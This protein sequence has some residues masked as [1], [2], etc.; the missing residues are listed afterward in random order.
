MS[1]TRQTMGNICYIYLFSIP[2]LCNYLLKI[3]QGSHAVSLTFAAKTR[4]INWKIRIRIISGIFQFTEI[5]YVSC[6]R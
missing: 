6:N 4:L 2:I 3:M 5:K 1:F